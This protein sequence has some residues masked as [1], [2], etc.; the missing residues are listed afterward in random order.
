MLITANSENKK[1]IVAS[2]IIKYPITVNL[3]Q[4]QGFEDSLTEGI[5]SDIIKNLGLCEAI[6]NICA[7]T[8]EVNL[9]KITCS[10]RVL[11][12]IVYMKNSRG[13]VTS[14]CKSN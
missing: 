9:V 7:K 13:I 2:K 6:E 11:E 10:L 8:M 4:K 1:V 12:K 5:T 3:L 14:W